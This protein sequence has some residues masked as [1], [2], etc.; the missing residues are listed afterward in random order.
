MQLC[1]VLL[2][3][4]AGLTASQSNDGTFYNPPQSGPVNDYSQ[5]PIYPVGSTVQ[6]RWTVSWDRISLT[7]WQSGNNDFEYLLRKGDSYFHFQIAKL[8]II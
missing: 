2:Y 8:L 4:L 3:L 6:I 5:N 1:S 7:L